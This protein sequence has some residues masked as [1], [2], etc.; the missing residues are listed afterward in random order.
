MTFIVNPETLKKLGKVI[1][2]KEMPVERP[3]FSSSGSGGIVKSL[4]RPKPF[5]F[6]ISIK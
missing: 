5:S 6:G 2:I 1:P 4:E 3:G